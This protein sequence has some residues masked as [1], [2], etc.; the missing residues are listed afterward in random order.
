MEDLGKVFREFRISKNYSLKEAAGE[1]CSTSQLSRFELGESDLAASRFFDI[2]DNIHVT[3]EN[4]MD[5]A[6]NFQHHEHVALMAQIIP[7]YYSNDIAGF[8]KLQREQLE[9]AK[10]STNPLYFELNWILL[11]GLICQR[12]ASYT[13]QQRDLDKVS[14]YLFQTEE[15]TMYELILFGNLYSFYDVF[16]FQK[17]K[18]Q[19]KKKRPQPGRVER[20]RETREKKKAHPARG[21]ENPKGEGGVLF[22]G[23]HPHPPLL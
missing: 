17:K 22:G 1:A 13:M 3:I 19:N 7:L 11:Q 10:H 5:K 20:V 15:W 18:T 2:L 14:D 8:Q 12:D 9:K 4:F 6:R 23:L 21:P 16:C